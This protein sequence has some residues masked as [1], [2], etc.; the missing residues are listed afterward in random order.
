MNASDN[1]FVKSSWDPLI[2]LAIPFVADRRFSLGGLAFAKPLA[3]L[4]LERFKLE[5]FWPFGGLRL[6]PKR[7]GSAL[8]NCPVLSVDG[9]FTPV[10]T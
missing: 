7:S 1:K 2:P 10:G 5:L 6:L 9:E 3:R 4:R 8:E